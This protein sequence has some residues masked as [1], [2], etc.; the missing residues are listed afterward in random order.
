MIRNAWIYPKALF[1][2]ILNRFSLYKLSV[3]KNEEDSYSRLKI[4]IKLIDK[5]IPNIL[6]DYERELERIEPKPKQFKESAKKRKAK[7][8]FKK[9]HKNLENLQIKAASTILS[10]VGGGYLP[11]RLLAVLKHYDAFWAVNTFLA[12]MMGFSYKNLLTST[13]ERKLLKEYLNL[14]LEADSILKNSK[15]NDLPLY[16]AIK[17]RNF[18][19]VK[20]YIYRLRQVSPIIDELKYSKIKFQGK[21][22]KFRKQAEIFLY[23]WQN[24]NEITI[25]R[26]L[27]VH[28]KWSEIQQQY[29]QIVEEINV[30]IAWI[31]NNLSQEK[32]EELNIIK[33]INDLEKAIADTLSLK[34][35]EN[36]GI[37]YLKVYSENLDSLIGEITA[38]QA[39]HL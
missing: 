25:Q 21:Y 4:S 17:K 39:N 36:K 35:Y 33:I 3:Q 11:F 31:D 5:D 12:T 24:L 27:N 14:L 9:P 8:S 28:S 16:E 10:I 2:L 18:K 32:R 29:D 19:L 37:K 22:T 26:I 15:L 23:S 20:S 38:K 7:L 1:L 13:N 30:R 34:D 6:V